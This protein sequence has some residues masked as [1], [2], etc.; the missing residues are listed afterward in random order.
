MKAKIIG[1]YFIITIICTFSF[2]AFGNYGYKG[3]FYNLGRATV[4]PINIFSDDT[5][6]D[7][8]N[9]ISFANTYNQVQAEHK[10]SEGVYLFNEAVGK[11]V[12]NMY[13]KNNNS[14]TYE[15]YD[16]FVNGTSSGYAHG[17]KMLASM[18]DNN[19]EMVKEFREYV[20]GMELIDVIDAGEEAH[21]ETK[22]LLNERRISASF[23]DMCVDMKVESFR[24]EAGQ[25]ALVIHDMLEEWKSECAS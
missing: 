11:I 3:F 17:Q 1:T 8:S 24:S 16:S 4:W 18:F 9:D 15:D 19:R 22:E 7:S 10:N 14:F 2:W 23:T 25:D 21:E 13:A 12:A 5:E 6:I 20:D